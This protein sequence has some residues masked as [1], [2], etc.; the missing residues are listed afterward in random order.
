MS[1]ERTT[2]M[3]N[4][5]A[6]VALLA[7]AATAIALLFLMLV[8]VLTGCTPAASKADPQASAAVVEEPAQTPPPVDLKPQF[9]EVF[10]YDNGVSISVSQPV[11]FTP[12]E[13]SSASTATGG[14]QWLYFKIVLTNNSGADIDPYTYESVSSGG[15]EAVSVF[16]MGNE[17]GAIGETPTTSVQNGQTVEWLVGYGVVDPASITFDIQP[18]FEYEKT[19]FT[20][21][22]P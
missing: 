13:W 19:T 18:G 20:N 12:T 6:P 7:P 1:L 5:K 9:G 22:L 11:P 17:L 15:K 21:I 2:L 10:T 14:E 3:D 8:L 16:D 4:L